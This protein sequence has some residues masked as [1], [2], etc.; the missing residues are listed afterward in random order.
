MREPTEP[1]HRVARQRFPGKASPKARNAFTKE[2]FD[3]LSWFTSQQGRSKMTEQGYREVG[4]VAGVIEE[5]LHFA[6]DHGL[7]P[8]QILE[9]ALM[10]YRAIHG[11]EGVADIDAVYRTVTAV[12]D[13]AEP[14]KE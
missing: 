14:T 9:K 4:V 6:A 11:F 12:L 13:A 5:A 7:S 3:H 10:S 8:L 2:L 1:V